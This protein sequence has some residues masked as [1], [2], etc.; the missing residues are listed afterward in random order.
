MEAMTLSKL[1]R[2]VADY[3]TREWIVRELAECGNWN[4]LAKRAGMDRTNLRRLARK[5]GA[6]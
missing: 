4:R 2:Q 1:R 3:F 6:L 5:V